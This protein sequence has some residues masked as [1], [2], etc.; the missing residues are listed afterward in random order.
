MK[1]LVPL[2]AC[3]LLLGGCGAKS[4]VP[5]EATPAKTV[6]QTKDETLKEAASQAEDK[7]ARL[8]QDVIGYAQEENGYTI[9]QITERR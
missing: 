4:G 6:T 7:G 3:A 5:E 9:C 8:L 1:K 2:M